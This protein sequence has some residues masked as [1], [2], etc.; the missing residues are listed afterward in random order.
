MMAVADRVS[1]VRP[2]A[3]VRVAPPPAQIQRC[4]G[5]Q[6]P[7]G[8]CNHDDDQKIHRHAEGGAGPLSPPGIVTSVLASAGQ[9]LDIS[10]R[11]LMEERFGHDFS[12]VRIHTDSAAARSAQAINAQAYTYGRHV[13]I[14]SGRYRP[15]TRDGV[16]LLAHELTHVVQQGNRAADTMAPRSISHPQEASEQEAHRMA[17]GLN[18]DGLAGTRPPAGLVQRQ[19][20]EEP[21]GFAGGGGSFGGGGASGSWEPADETENVSMV[22]LTCESTSDGTID[23]HLRG[24]GMTS[25]RLTLCDLTPGDY[26]AEVEVVGHDLTLRFDLPG[27]LLFRFAYVV[28]PGQ[29]DPSTFFGDQHRVPVRARSGVPT[30]TAPALPLVCSR[31]LDFPAWTGLRNFRHAYI[32][33]PPA[34]Y[35]IRGLVSGNGVTA[36]CSTATDA[37]GTPDVPATS[38][39]KECLPAP[40]Q[41]KEDVSRCLRAT[42]AAY[43]SPNLYRNLPDPHDSFRHGPNSN[44]YAAAMAR[45]CYNFSPSGLGIL[46]GWS[47]SPAGPCP[48][49]PTPVLP[50]EEPAPE[51]GQSEEPAP[52]QSGEARDAGAPGEPPAGAGPLGGQDTAPTDLHAFGNRSKP[53]DPRLGIDIDPNPDGSVGPEPKEPPWPDGASTFGDPEKAPLTGHH[54]RIVAG[55]RMT[56]G[57]RVIADGSEA[58]GPQRETHHTI[59]PVEQMLFQDFVDRFQGLGWAYAGKR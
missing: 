30:P 19:S 50:S 58:G 32:N 6:C 45:C 17:G 40:G 37:S 9:A 18:R 27:G 54:H 10:T 43:P 34:N 56:T 57:L 21:G 53:R 1:P 36:S 55:T 24:G 14:G 15:D 46:P 12:K 39:C 41:T 31:P 4:G 33:D 8:T 28:D 48:P 52:E 13:V 3:A 35:A 16:E 26:V 51:P 29:Q 42:H 25:Y 38:I 23:F 20:D 5:V 2:P 22:E 7:P 59:F 44:S 47:H 49:A 11:K